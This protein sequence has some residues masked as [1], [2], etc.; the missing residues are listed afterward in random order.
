MEM[1]AHVLEATGSSTHYWIAGQ[2]GR[3]L[4]VFTH[5]AAIDHH[6]WDAT[7]PVVANRYRVLVWDMPGHGLSRPGRFSVPEAVDQL[8]AILDRE[9]I[10]QAAFVGHS[11]GGNLHQ[12]LVFRFPER[13]ASMVCVDC[14]WNFQKLSWWESLLVTL[15]EPMFRLYPHQL[16]VNQ[17]LAEA[18]T[19]AASQALLRPA[20]SSMSKD[21]IIQVMMA[22]TTCL[23][24][25]PGYVV[26]KPLLMFLGDK[27][28]T[29]NIRKA[30]PL[31]ARQ[32]PNCRLVVVPGV[33]HSPNLDAP[34][35]FHTELMGFLRT[36]IG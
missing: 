27:D 1:Q 34:D 8:V 19:S 33:K 7:M 18:A 6:E 35:L 12:E 11:L 13:V 29:G 14:T 25:E 31:W 23:H 9:G 16:L 5:G 2:A 15:A 30:M 20:M 26:N 10:Q 3:P 22:A 36:T 28:R 17:A 32:E 4:V 21:E 24:H